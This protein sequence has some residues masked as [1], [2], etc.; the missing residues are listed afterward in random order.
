MTDVA[1]ATQWIYTFAE[2]SR[3]MQ[4]LRG[5]GMAMIFQ[6]P[7]SS[8]NPVLARAPTFWASTPSAPPR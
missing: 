3:E 6:E 7:M 8:L 4:D 2:G 1:G 5:N